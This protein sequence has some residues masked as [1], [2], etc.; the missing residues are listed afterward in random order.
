MFKIAKLSQLKHLASFFQVNLIKGYK[1]ID[2]AGEIVNIYHRNNTP[3]PFSMD[4]DGLSIAQ[5][6]EDVAELRVTSKTF[7]MRFEP[8]QTEGEITYIAASLDHL[9]QT[10]SKEAKKVLDVLEVEEMSR[11]GW[12]NYFAFDFNNKEESENYWKSLTP[13]PELSL[14]QLTFTLQEDEIKGKLV[15]T[16]A[17]K[18]ED[19]KEE[20]HSV[21]FD[22]DLSLHGNFRKNDIEHKLKGFR[23]YLNG[24]DQF[25]KLVSSSPTTAEEVEA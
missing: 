8:G 17:I 23:A 16:R 3:P 19:D 18:K 5:P 13:N 24:E 1:Y 2:R 14:N 21:L 9:I 22:I 11:I 25:L 12:R 7:W 10:Y 6:L 15:I 4:L 20:V